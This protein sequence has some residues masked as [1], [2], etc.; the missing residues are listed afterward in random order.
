MASKYIFLLAKFLE[1]SGRGF[2]DNR[3]GCS[4]TRT[5]YVRHSNLQKQKRTVFDR[6]L[7]GKKPPQK[8]RF[9]S[10]GLP[11]RSK[12]QA[13][14]HN[15]LAPNLFHGNTSVISLSFLFIFHI[16]NIMSGSFLRR[17]SRRR[18][19]HEKFS[20][21]MIVEVSRCGCQKM[22]KTG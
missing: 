3:S 1:D 6:G 10:L 21:G 19:K 5:I 22:R 13:S 12:Q 20:V 15:V 9:P 14:T 17:S 2:F 4:G 7:D 18:E 8:G 16:I 11:H